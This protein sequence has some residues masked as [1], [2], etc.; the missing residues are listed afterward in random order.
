MLKYISQKA[1]LA[2]DEEGC[3]ATAFTEA[4]ITEDCTASDQPLKVTINRSFLFAILRDAKPIVTGEV[5]DPA[6][7]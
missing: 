1:Y 3:K 6:E 2:V 7:Q 5:D 4:G